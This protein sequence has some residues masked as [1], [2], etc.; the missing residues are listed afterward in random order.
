[1]KEAIEKNEGKNWKKIAEYLVNRTHTQCLHR[2]QK[3]LNPGLVKGAWT[4]EVFQ[5][6][7]IGF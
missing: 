7:L 4:A 3:V 6:V 2:W 5:Y 1:L